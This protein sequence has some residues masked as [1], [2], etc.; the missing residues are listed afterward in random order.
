MSRFKLGKTGKAGKS[1]KSRAK[2]GFR[3]PAVRWV[4]YFGMLIFLYMIMVG[5]FFASWQP[6]LIIPLAIAV[7]MRESEVKAAL[8]GAVCGLVID[9]ACGKLFGFSGIW[10]LPGC[11]GAS[12]LVSNLI[13]VN[14]LNFLWV[15]A[16]VCA[17]MAASD[18]FF[19]YALWNMD[20][21]HYVL[22]GFI[23]PSHLSA[24]VLSPLIY[25][26]VKF[27]SEKISQSNKSQFG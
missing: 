16:V 8:F 6:V 23:I 9:I 2:F 21:A 18:Y 7:A 12:L 26:S 17:I 24:V 22:T 10:L 19:R 14:L 3:S 1:G 5:G 4:F 13:K 20:N 11:L 15:N 27:I 25:L